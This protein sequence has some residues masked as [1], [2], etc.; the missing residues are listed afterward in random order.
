MPRLDDSNALQIS[1]I[2]NSDNPVDVCLPCYNK[3]RVTDDVEHPNYD[4]TDPVYYCAMC[5][6]PLTSAD[7]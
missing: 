3:L 4:E 7:N 2:F 5:G 1:V 6:E